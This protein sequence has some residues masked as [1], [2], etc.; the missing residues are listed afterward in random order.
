MLR[1]YKSPGSVAAEIIMTRTVHDGAFLVV[2]GRDD[3]RFWEPRRHSDCQ[4]VDGEGKRNV[5]QGIGRLPPL[6]CQG[7]LGVVDDD[8]DSLLGVE[9][10][11][12]NVVATDAHDLECLL[13]RSRALDTVLVEYGSLTKIQ[14]FEE[15]ACVDVRAG[16]LERAMIF[17]RVR[18]AAKLYRLGIRYEAIRVQRFV[19]RTTWTVD[20]EGLIRA[21]VKEGS[22][23]DESVVA[24]RVGALSEADSWRVVQGHDM[25]ELLRIGL[26][27]VLGDMKASVGTGQIASVLRAAMSREEL[28]HTQLWADM[29][30]WEENTGRRY[31]VLAE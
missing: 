8:Y 1:E 23:D 28:Q 26:M 29:R 4:L 20:S 6:K 13:C 24:K 18:W 14:R 30:T 5:I 25:L 10:R 16:L 22:A 12:E 2:E 27:S 3:S 17:G 31:L 7:V 15:D 9:R 11:V 21:V 19:D